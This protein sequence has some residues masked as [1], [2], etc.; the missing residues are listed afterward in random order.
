MFV[1]HL[2][3]DPAYGERA[4]SILKAIQDGEAAVTSTLA[5]AQV[6]GYM[7]WKKKADR[8]PAFLSL[9]RSM[10]SMSK[11]E[12]TFADF[13]RAREKMGDGGD[14]RAWDDYVIA[15]QMER[16]GTKEVY[17]ND[18]DFDAIEGTRRIF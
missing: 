16:S 11:V 17:S 10:P 3:D 9:L 13:V 5:I 12:T 1:Y 15:A 18:S 4:R 2:S 6:C 7:K 14:W 8:I